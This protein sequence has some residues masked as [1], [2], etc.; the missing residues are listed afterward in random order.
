MWARR[1]HRQRLGQCDVGRAVHVHFKLRLFAGGSASYEFT[2][3]F[4]F[5]D[6]LTDT[7]HA[8]SPY[9][10]RGTR[11][12]RNTADSIYNSLSASEKAALTLQ[13]T[14]SGSG[15]TGVIDL[16]VNVG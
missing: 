7:V 9:S 11:N 13:A 8:L 14:A 1:G 2:S 6:S 12:T 3:Q 16:D 10:G 4:F 15:Y 5:D